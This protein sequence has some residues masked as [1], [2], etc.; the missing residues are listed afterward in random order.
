[1][2]KNGKIVVLDSIPQPRKVV[3]D[4]SL[5]ENETQLRDLP[6]LTLPE[7]IDRRLFPH[8][9]YGVNWLYNLHLT[10]SGGLLGDEM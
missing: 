10:A 3:V 5:N 1:M 4:L 7:V 6:N 9:K 2:K 8:Q